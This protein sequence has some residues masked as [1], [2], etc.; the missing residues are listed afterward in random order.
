MGQKSKPTTFT[1][2]M[3]SDNDQR[4]QEDGSY[5]DAQNIQLI[6]LEILMKN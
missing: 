3:I 1:K 5:R 6:N 2:G 4:F